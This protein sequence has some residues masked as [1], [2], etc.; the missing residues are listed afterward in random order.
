MT[1][2]TRAKSKLT[3]RNCSWK[4]YVNRLLWVHRN[5]RIKISR[6]AR[7]AESWTAIL[8]LYQQVQWRVR[9][10]RS[11]DEPTIFLN[12]FSVTIVPLL[13]MNDSRAMAHRKSYCIVSRVTG[14]M[15]C[16]PPTHIG[17][18][19]PTARGVLLGVIMGAFW[20]PEP[21]EPILPEGLP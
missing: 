15:G 16:V 8:R 10:A 4:K 1:V 9:R 2:F 5:F 14:F 18:A 17:A 21:T 12:M 20:E 11:I 3:V 13:L 7:R 6:G 19:V